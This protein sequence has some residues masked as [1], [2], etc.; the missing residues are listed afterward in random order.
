MAW[1]ICGSARN[2][3]GWGIAR[4]PALVLRLRFGLRTFGAS[5]SSAS[6]FESNPQ[7]AEYRP[8]VLTLSPISK[9]G[10]G[11]WSVVCFFFENGRELEQVDEPRATFIFEI[12]AYPEPR[13]LSAS[14]LK[15]LYQQF[16][17]NL[18]VAEH[19]GSSLNFVRDNRKKL[20]AGF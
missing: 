13:S 15:A 16:G 11:L 10:D 19:I 4:A 2:G 1:A 9:C 5:R 8:W 18:R 7:E 20:K 14:Q 12:E 6:A 17:T 3:R